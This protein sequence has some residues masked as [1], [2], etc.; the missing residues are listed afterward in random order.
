MRSVFS[1]QRNEKKVLQEQEQGTASADDGS[2]PL[3]LCSGERESCKTKAR[4]LQH[5]RVGDK[6]SVATCNGLCI[7]GGV[8]A[9][10]VP[11]MVLIDGCKLAGELGGP[12]TRSPAEKLLWSSK[13]RRGRYKRPQG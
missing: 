2:G 10:Y 7:P 11:W 1:R 8:W 13:Q 4:C 9:S 6:P 12:E 3:I 5:R